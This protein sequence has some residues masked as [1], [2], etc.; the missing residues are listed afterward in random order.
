MSNN[1][2]PGIL[3]ETPNDFEEELTGKDKCHL[4]LFHQ[5]GKIYCLPNE[6]FRNVAEGAG[7]GKYCGNDRLTLVSA[8]LILVTQP[9][10][11]VIPDSFKIVFSRKMD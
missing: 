9:A 8:I 2:H 11:D 5:N 1:A 10:A 6:S 3:L 4:Y 7:G